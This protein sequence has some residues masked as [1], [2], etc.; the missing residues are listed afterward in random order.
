[1]LDNKNEKNET[2][3]FPTASC[4]TSTDIISLLHLDI[5]PGMKKEIWMTETKERKGMKEAKKMKRMK[6]KAFVRKRRGRR[7]TKL[8]RLRRRSNCWKMV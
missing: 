5:F 2:F 3:R 1:M 8:R 4:L 7:K 6:E